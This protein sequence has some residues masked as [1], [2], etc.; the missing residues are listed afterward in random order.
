MRWKRLGGKTNVDYTQVAV[1]VLGLVTLARGKASSSLTQ[2]L[3]AG[4]SSNPSSF[5]LA[6]YSGLW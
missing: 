3:F 4:T 5:A 6:L 1:L 2:P